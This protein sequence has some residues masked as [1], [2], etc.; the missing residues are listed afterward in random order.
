MN[1]EKTLKT[2]TKELQKPY[3]QVNMFDAILLAILKVCYLQKPL[4]NSLKNPRQGLNRNNDNNN[5]NNNNN[6]KK[7]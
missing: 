6:N 7:K 3:G 5:N 4:Q 2:L 1:Y